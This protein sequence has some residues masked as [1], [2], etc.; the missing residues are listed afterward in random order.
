MHW[1]HCWDLWDFNPCRSRSCRKSWSCP[2]PSS[3][4]SSWRRATQPSLILYSF[5]FRTQIRDRKCIAGHRERSRCSVMRPVSKNSWDLQN[6]GQGSRQGHVTRSS[7][8]PTVSPEMFRKRNSSRRP[9]RRPGPARDTRTGFSKSDPRRRWSFA[10]QV[11]TAPEVGFRVSGYG[12]MLTN[13]DWLYQQDDKMCIKCPYF[14]PTWLD[15]QLNIK[16]ARKAKVFQL[17]KWSTQPVW[18]EKAIFERNFW[19]FSNKSSPN[20]CSV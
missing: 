20:I 3:W 8:S 1:A 9:G 18:P 11:L 2:T 10:F 14:M 17:S 4:T 12:I 15:Y 6:A 19:N 13:S 7:L 16:L 5:R